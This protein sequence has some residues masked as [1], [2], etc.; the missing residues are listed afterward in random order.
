MR[1]SYNWL[2]SYVNLDGITPETLAQSLTFAGLEVEGME[3]LAQG[4]NLVVGEVVERIPHP[5]SDHLNICK[6]DIGTE[7]LQIVCGAPNVAVGQK[8]IVALSGAVL[9]EL[10]IQAGCIRGV[11][12]NGMICSLTELGVDKKHL[13]EDRVNG[14]EVLPESAVAGDKNPLGVLGLDD[15]IIELSLTPNRND[16]LAMWA[17]AKEVGAVL[18]REV[19]LPANL[20]DVREGKTTLKISSTTENCPYFVAKVVKKLT[21]KESPEWMKKALLAVGVKSINNVVDIS[22]YVMLETGQPLHF[23]DIAKMPA[24]EITVKDQLT[25]TYTALDGIEYK[26]ES[27]D[28][29]ITSNGQP[30]GI[31]G[32]MGGDDSKIEETTTGIIIEAASFDRVAIRK[33]ARRLNL[34]TEAS[35][36][37]QKGIEPIAA[38]KA[39]DRSLQL[40]MELADAELI[41]ETVI[42]GSNQYQP[43][44][45]ETTT[46]FTNCLLGTELTEEE[47]VDV[48]H[49]LDFEPLLEEGKIQVTIPSY[50]TDIQYEVDLTEEII[51]L[52]GYDKIP[53]TL[54][55]M[56]TTIGSYVKNE[57]ERYK[58]KEVLNGLGLT[59]VITYSLVSKEMIEAG[60]MPIGEV[61]ELASPLSEERKYYRTSLL[62]S[63]VDVISYNQARS[64]ENWGLFEVASVYD[65][66]GNQQERLSMAISQTM[67][68]SR[69]QKI[70][71]IGD[72]YIIKGRI[73][74]LLYELGFDEKRIFVKKN[75]VNTD[76]F[77]PNQS[78]TIYI[79]RNLLGVFGRVHP[80]AQEN[81]DISNCVLAELNLDVL[82]SSKPAKVK[83]TPIPKYPSVSYDI[84][85]LVEEQVLTGDIIDLVKK[86]GGKLVSSAEVFDVY[87]GNNIPEG[88]KSIAV[89]IVYQSLE[90]TL[91][92]KDILP[93]QDKIIEALRK[94]FSI[95]Y[96]DK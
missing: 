78:A 89:H 92:D 84:A 55:T 23:Y 64:Q 91:K 56:P 60:V 27:E 28:L 80:K 42:Y 86:T 30:I 10:T 74:S 3:R 70:S 73:L 36:R 22:N 50:R 14:I 31:A 52:I 96:R 2:K 39:V 90:E 57:K 34:Q 66:D 47:I 59:E 16:C 8:V 29:M 4:S 65:N 49:R 20:L 17:L 35:I 79:D 11:E 54:P 63:L 53:S 9:P 88:M 82:Y 75:D 94:Q 40:L 1:V 81:Y 45:L 71:V 68:Y 48:L 83:Y 87:Q 43:V 93:I 58:I 5:D 33:T 6:V 67:T 76:L 12:S 51:R 61:V 72:F 62:P 37:F 24:L 95:I 69:W 21:I 32:I 26:I 46:E 85:F 15:T 41:E 19:S 13:E 77:H 18:D 7:V 38:Q 25:T 44:K